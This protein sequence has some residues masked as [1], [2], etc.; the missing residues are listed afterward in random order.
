MKRLFLLSLLLVATATAPV[1]AQS[2]GNSTEVDPPTY[3]GSIDQSTRIVDYQYQDGVFTVW[4]ESDIPTVLVVSDALGPL[5]DSGV[6]K[7]P[8]K[9]TSIPGGRSKITMPVES[10]RGEAGISVATSDGAAYISTGVDPANPWAGGNA[11]LGWIGG[12][13]IAL[14]FFILAG[15]YV[16]RKEGG[17]PQEATP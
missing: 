10:F 9:R 5:S 8:Q 15:V 2:A 17:A 3:A 16:I 4:I 13:G 12:A 7:I 11:T 1:A 14:L 6:T